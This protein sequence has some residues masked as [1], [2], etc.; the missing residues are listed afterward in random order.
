MSKITWLISSLLAIAACNYGDN[1]ETGPCFYAPQVDV[2][3][4]DY[5]EAVDDDGELDSA[6]CSALCHTYYEADD[7]GESP[8]LSSPE[9]MIEAVGATLVTM[10][11]MT[12]TPC[13]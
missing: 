3:R 6:E 12:E 9:C 13:A 11:C 2:P 10:H 4:A 5:D 7:S 1:T 8:S